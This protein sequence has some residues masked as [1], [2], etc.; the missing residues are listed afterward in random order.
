[1]SGKT[2][3][4]AKSAVSRWAPLVV[5]GTIAAGIV[6]L[7]VT[8]VDTFRAGAWT[9][10]APYLVL[11]ALAEFLTVDAYAAEGE[12]MSLSFA[13][14]VTTAASVAL[15]HGAPLIA[16]PMALAGGVIQRR[17]TL[18]KNLF[19]MANFALAMYASRLAFSAFPLPSSMLEPWMLLAMLTALLVF[20]VVNVGLV[21]LVVSLHSGEPVR[22]VL[23]GS[24]WYA[25]NKFAVGLI[26]GGVAIVY[27]QV[28]ALGALIFAL[29]LGVLR[30]T[31]TLYTRQTQRTI[32]ALEH[33]ARHDLLTGLPN[34]LLLRERTQTA[35]DR[36]AQDASLHGSLLLLDLDRFKEVNDT[37]GHYAGDRLLEQIGRRLRERVRHP[38]RRRL[39]SP[40]RSGGA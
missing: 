4:V 10:L 12:H 22:A 38:A 1:M 8:L 2:A 36:A 32:D 31:L 34:R 23:Q 19:N 15:P 14:A 21:S 5:W 35:V 29:P 25:P 6:V 24:A 11:A 37:F 30:Y 27:G 39:L 7:E 20:Q 33:Q 26:G 18:Q 28:G 9:E 3:A 16:V 40:I 13:I 17:R